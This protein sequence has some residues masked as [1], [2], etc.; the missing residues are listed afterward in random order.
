VLPL[1]EAGRCPRAT[2]Y[3]LNEQQELDDSVG[4]YGKSLLWLVS[5]AFEDRRGTPLLGIKHYLKAEPALQ[6]AAF[7]EIIEST[8]KTGTGA[9]CMAEA[10]GGFDND[11]ASMNAVLTRIL[12]KKPAV[13]FEARDLG[14]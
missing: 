12:G 4:P 7:A 8:G 14:Y 11:P 1:I 5:T 3:H 6:Q 13:L 10:H 2:L 9:Q